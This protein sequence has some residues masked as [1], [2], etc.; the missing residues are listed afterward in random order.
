MNS[1]IAYRIQSKANGY[2]PW[3][4][5]FYTF[6]SVW[7]SYRSNGDPSFHGPYNDKLEKYVNRREYVF[8]CPSKA[9]LR[10]W[11]GRE[12]FIEFFLEYNYHIVKFRVIEPHFAVG[13]N[14][15]QMVFDRSK[16]VML[17]E[18]SPEKLRRKQKS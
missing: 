17:E 6:N 3:H 7:C 12:E 5:H 9:L 2:G 16:A 1:A 14:G 4:N 13:K 8:G 15:T 11:F 10:K 18:Y